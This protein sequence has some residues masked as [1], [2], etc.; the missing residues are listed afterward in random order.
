MEKLILVKIYAQGLVNALGDDAEFAVVSREL[1][2]FGEK[3]VNHP[4]LKEILASPFV[5]GRKKAQVI[6]EIL[7]VSG[8]AGKTQR[9]I[10]LLRE[11]NRLG[12]LGDIQ[13]ALPVVW[14][15]SRGLA[16]F[17]VSSVVSLSEAQKKGLQK[18]LERLEGR[19]VFL[20]FLIDPGLVAG[21]SLRKGNLIYDASVKGQLA[22]IKERISEG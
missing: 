1:A 9:F 7:A 18:E 14:H 4:A 5:A 3:I 22:K 6:Q 10:L 11:H 16:T 13:E 15:E 2:D 20:R 8:F 17:E 19:P 21:L 12:L